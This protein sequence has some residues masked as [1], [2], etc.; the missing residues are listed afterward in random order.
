MFKLQRFTTAY[1]ENEDRIKLTG[2]CQSDQHVMLWLTQRLLLNLVPVMLERIQKS[3][4]EPAQIQTVMQEFAQQAART[5]MP[6][7]PAVQ[8]KDDSQ[9]WLIHSIDVTSTP[10][11][12]ELAMKGKNNDC[13]VIKLEGQLL[14]QW[15]NILYD[16]SLKANWPLSIWPDWIQA[17]AQPKSPV[18]V[19]KH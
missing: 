13:A 4:E 12:L 1:D 2:H 6:S 11:G 10:E 18:N 17:S 7:L 8:A 9:S 19:V 3:V 15:L 16:L 14:R 5:Q